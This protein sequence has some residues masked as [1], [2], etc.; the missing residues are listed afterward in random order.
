M[1]TIM[2]TRMINYDDDDDDDDDDDYTLMTVIM[3]IRITIVIDIKAMTQMLNG[4]AIE[5]PKNYTL[6]YVL[7]VR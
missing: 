7:H 1:M 4:Q 3:K 5:V 6:Q 2:L